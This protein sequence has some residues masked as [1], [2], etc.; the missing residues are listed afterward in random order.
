MIR[1][2]FLSFLAIGVFF[3]NAQSQKLFAAQ[4]NGV[5]FA[6]EDDPYYVY[7]MPARK[8]AESI[9]EKQ[10]SK[11]LFLYASWCPH[12]RSALPDVL[13][14]ASDVK[15][16]VIAVSVDKN[17]EDLRRYMKTHGDIPF[18]LIVWDGSDDLPREF[19]A[20]G[21]KVTGGIPFFVLMNADGSIV[22][23]GTLST[24]VVAKFVHAAQKAQHKGIH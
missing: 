10:T 23:Q 16:S 11:V 24:D 18:P 9:L 20:F 7:E 21:A 12:C 8:I 4:E 3:S 2:L 14:L 17:P 13:E 22:R 1:F 19:E 6:L 5:P 15:G